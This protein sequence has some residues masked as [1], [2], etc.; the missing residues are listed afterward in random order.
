MLQFAFKWARWCNGL[1]RLQQGYAIF[2][3]L[4]SSPTYDQCSFFTCNKV[5]P[6]NNQIPMLTLCAMCPNYLAQGYQRLHVKQANKKFNW[7]I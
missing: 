6:L 4:G 1:A 5:S 2:K 7:N 3:D